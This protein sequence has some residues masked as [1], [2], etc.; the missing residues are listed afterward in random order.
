MTMRKTT[1][2][3]MMMEKRKKKN[4][5]GI[6]TKPDRQGSVGCRTFALLLKVVWATLPQKA[7]WVVV[8]LLDVERNTL[9]DGEKFVGKFIFHFEP[10]RQLEII[11][12]TPLRGPSV[13]VFPLH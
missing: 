10:F 3:M 12:G 13:I 2:M 7:Q 1:M 6:E 4:S 11:L 5:E 9:K 8:P